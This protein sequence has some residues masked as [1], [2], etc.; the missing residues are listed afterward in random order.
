[1]FAWKGGLRLVGVLLVVLS[2]SLLLRITHAPGPCILFPHQTDTHKHT[3]T[4]T[5]TSTHTHN[6]FV[7]GEAVLTPLFLPPLLL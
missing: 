7:A 6:N 3:H 4:P 5:H 1:M 2:T